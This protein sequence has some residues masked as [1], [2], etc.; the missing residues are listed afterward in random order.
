MD[1]I[2]G[3]IDFDWVDSHG[4]EITIDSAYPYADRKGLTICC[5]S[6]KIYGI[7]LMVSFDNEKDIPITSK[8]I[9]IDN[10]LDMNFID[11]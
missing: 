8:I 2:T 6:G 10:L 11:G 4:N 1:N 9:P 5:D 7:K 3:Y